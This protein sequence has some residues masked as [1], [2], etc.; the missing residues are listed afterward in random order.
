MLVDHQSAITNQSQE[1][2][3]AYPSGLE[4]ATNYTILSQTLARCMP[5]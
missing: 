1:I 5:T 2:G 3:H 4:R